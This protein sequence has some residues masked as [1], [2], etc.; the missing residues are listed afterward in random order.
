MV[1]VPLRFF[2]K[3]SWISFA[4]G[5]VALCAFSLC[6]H[7][8][9]YYYDSAYY[10][11]LANSFFESG[12]FSL[13]TYSQSIRGVCFPLQ[14]A[15]PIQLARWT[16]LSSFT[17]FV[18]FSSLWFS[19]V[20]TMVLPYVFSFFSGRNASVWS[21]LGLVAAVMVF[22]RGLLLFPLSDFYAMSMVFFAMALLL[23]T[24]TL[25]KASPETVSKTSRQIFPPIAAALSGALAY[26]AYNM[27]T[28]YIFAAV[29]LTVLMVLCIHKT[30]WTTPCL[31]LP[32]FV[33]GIMAAALPQM[34]VNFKQ[35]GVLSPRVY[36]QSDIYAN[37]LFVFQFAAGL[38]TQLFQ[39]L[40][41]EC[42]DLC[43][44]EYFNLADPVGLKMAEQLKQVVETGSGGSLWLL[45]QYAFSYVG[46]CFRHIVQMLNP[47]FGEI[48]ITNPHKIKI[49]LTIIN[50]ALMICTCLGL[51]RSIMRI[52]IADMPEQGRT[53]RAQAAFKTLGSIL[54][55]FLPLILPC[56]AIIPGAPEQR[57]FLPLYMLMYAFLAFC[58]DWKDLAAWIKR[59]RWTVII[60]SLLLLITFLTLIS[61][62]WTNSTL[63]AELAISMW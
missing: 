29:C 54:L 10:F 35:L 28:V 24:T 27:R 26:A 62:A 61:A 33:A 1:S 36:T 4:L 34:L 41:Y 58:L 22:W 16:G 57:F 3:Q 8:S 7:V 6:L 46:V 49:Q 44:V 52:Q 63:P 59:R 60:S 53:S 39:T 55:W 11:D 17:A 25:L 45:A 2:N 51:G 56:L 5:F 14:L 38:K 37:G 23:R 48:Y 30:G 18:L 19:F 32:L 43:G 47:I 12:S 21:R 13:S 20:C 42:F 15:L 40:S 50:F 9:H 31:C